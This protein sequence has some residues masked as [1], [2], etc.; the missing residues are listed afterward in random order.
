MKIVKIS[1]LLLLF[2]I[3]AALTPYEASLYGSRILVC[4]PGVT[5][6]HWAA[7]QFEEKGRKGKE[8]FVLDLM[9]MQ[10]YPFEECELFE[11]SPRPD[12]MKPCKTEII[13]KQQKDK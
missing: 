6:K 2:C 8:N 13:V 5:V 9:T 10:S 11:C 1:I 12:R 7:T 3:L 4:Y